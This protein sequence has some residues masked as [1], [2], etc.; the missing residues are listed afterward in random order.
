MSPT[1][2]A[3]TANARSPRR[4]PRRTVSVRYMSTFLPSRYQSR[5]TPPRSISSV[6]RPSWR[7][8]TIRSPRWHDETGY[9][10]GPR[11]QRGGLVPDLTRVAPLGLGLGLASLELSHPSWP[12]SVSVVDAVTAA[13]GWWIPLHV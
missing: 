7:R 10:H 2:R 5:T 3:S 13:G 11:R 6:C 8:R 9:G 4:S 12:A 1:S